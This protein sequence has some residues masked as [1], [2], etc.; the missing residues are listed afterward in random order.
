MLLGFYTPSGTTDL[1]VDLGSVSQITSIYGTGSTISFSSKFNLSDI[2]T[3]LGSINNINMGIVA[4]ENNTGV[5]GYVKKTLWLTS[6]PN[7]GFGP[8]QRGSAS[9]QGN[10]QAKIATLGGAFANLTANGSSSV[11]AIVSTGSGNTYQEVLGTAGNLGNTF[12]QTSV[13]TTTPSN[14]SSGGSA[15]LDFYE[16]L[17]T[18]STGGTTGTSSTSGDGLY[19]GYFL[20]NSN[21]TLTFTAVPEASTYAAIF[22]GGLMLL[23]LAGVHRKS[24]A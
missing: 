7:S 12:N 5:S 2:N 11:A 1:Q 9:V 10:S 18:G 23:A 20:L 22:A 17:P 14:L 21:G 13:E 24:M 19:L 3:A 6:D 4:S 8:L 15:R 16:L